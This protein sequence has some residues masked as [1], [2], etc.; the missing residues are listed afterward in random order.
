MM[1]N[2]IAKYGY[3][4]L[5][6]SRVIVFVV[7][8]LSLSGC[9]APRTADCS[10]PP[11]PANPRTAADYSLW[12]AYYTNRGDMDAA[13]NSYTQA[14]NLAT[15]AESRCGCLVNRGIC[16]HNESQYMRDKSAK[17]DL[18]GAEADFTEAIRLCPDNAWARQVRGL[19]YANTGSVDKG[20]EDFNFLVAR[21]PE[22]PL[23]LMLRSRAYMVRGD[24]DK[25]LA[26]AAEAISLTKGKPGEAFYYS[27]RAGIRLKFE[28]VDGALEDL[29]KSIAL[30][31][32]ENKCAMLLCKGDIL[33]ANGRLA[34]AMLAYQQCIKEAD[35]LHGAAAGAM[36]GTAGVAASYGAA[37]LKWIHHVP[38]R[39]R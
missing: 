24:M 35:R 25:A 19:F 21:E 7:T 37:A 33:R 5:E 2:C 39:K 13:V 29:D 17:Q 26:D 38:A 32:L 1:L 6:K 4:V 8:A 30:G 23:Y 27:Q 3:A 22:N 14:L 31:S 11:G 34:D 36:G 10:V 15:D 18:V 12:A 16:R 28:D 20:L 9:A